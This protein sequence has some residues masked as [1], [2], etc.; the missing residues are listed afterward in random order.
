[1][2][3]RFSLPLFIPKYSPSSPHP[4]FIGV[5]LSGGGGGEAIG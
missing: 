5:F 3:S 1:V 4:V 2:K